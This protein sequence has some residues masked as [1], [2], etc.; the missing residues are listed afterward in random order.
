[1]TCSWFVS[2]YVKNGVCSEAFTKE[3]GV[4]PCKRERLREASV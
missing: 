3:G 4:E 2:L 1:M